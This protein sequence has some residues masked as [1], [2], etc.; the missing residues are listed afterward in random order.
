MFQSYLTK[1]R[2]HANRFFGSTLPTAARNSYN[3]LNTTLVPGAHKAHRFLT[4][5][6]SELERNPDVSTKNK[7]RLKDIGKFADIGLSRIN[8]FHET[9]NNVAH[10][11]A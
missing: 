4:A 5:A 9:V 8:N 6:A 3:F 10:R 7:S 2:G 1:A 11:V